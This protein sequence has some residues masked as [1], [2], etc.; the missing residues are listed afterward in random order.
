M[1]LPPPA[2][3]GLT[4]GAIVAPPGALQWRFSRASGPGG[5]HVNKTSS[6][7]ELVVDLAQLRGL[8]PQMLMRLRTLAGRRIDT[9]NLLH[10][11]SDVHRSQQMNRDEVLARLQTLLTEA[12]QVPKVRRPTRT[13]RSVVRRRLKAKR[14]RSAIKAQRSTPD[15]D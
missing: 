4:F 14:I 9:Q 7:A 2:E 12:Q 5:Q 10:L 8:S 15:E 3:P 6:R 13:P 1:S 11:I